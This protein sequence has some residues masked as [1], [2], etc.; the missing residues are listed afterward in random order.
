MFYRFVITSVI[1]VG[2]L[3]SSGCG[4]GRL[5]LADPSTVGFKLNKEELVKGKDVAGTPL[6]FKGARSADGLHFAAAVKKGWKQSVL[7][8][9]KYV[10]SDWDEIS[11][12]VFS[13]DGLHMAFVARKASKWCVVVDGKPQQEF[14]GIGV[15]FGDPATYHCRFWAATI[16]VE[17][18]SRDLVHVIYAARDGNKTCVVVD[19]KPGSRF[20]GR[21]IE[22]PVLSHDFKH[23]FYFV[24][25]DDLLDPYKAWLYL[26]LDGVPVV[27]TDR[28]FDV[29]PQFDEQ[30][31]LDLIA[32]CR[33]GTFDKMKFIPASR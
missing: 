30:G 4:S 1:I 23:V 5:K 2:F 18:P 20:D 27:E 12:I 14:D 33:N 24:A 22:E 19:G 6:V 3:V 7:W 10:D 28:L 31:A 17:E 32:G 26:F 9:G 16:V 21:L 29:P 15:L 25:Q 11:H 8:D 13:D